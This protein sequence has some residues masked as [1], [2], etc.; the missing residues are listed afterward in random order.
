MKQ[1]NRSLFHK[2]VDIGRGKATLSFAREKLCS[3][4]GNIFSVIVVQ[5]GLP[6]LSTRG[7]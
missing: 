5:R 7:S 3:S 2:K 1:I 4:E 6:V